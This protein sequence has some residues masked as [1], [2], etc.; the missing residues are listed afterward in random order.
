MVALGQA[1]D[2]DT[3]L[4]TSLALSGILILLIQPGSL[5]EA[6]TQLSF[7]VSFSLVELTR[8]LEKTFPQWLH[9]KLRTGLAAVLAAEAASVPLVAW[10]FGMYCWTATLAVLASSP[11]LGLIIALGLMVALLGGAGSLAFGAPAWG[12][13]FYQFTLSKPA[14]C[15][16][17][18]GPSQRPVDAGGTGS[19][20]CFC[21]AT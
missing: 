16:I 2:L 7:M 3:D 19:S 10:H 21:H 1:L 11:L 6:G 5:F 13:G 15:G 4:A 20:P 14:A 8:R 12:A 9:P 18:C 17:F